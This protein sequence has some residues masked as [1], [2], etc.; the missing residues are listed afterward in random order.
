MFK[1]TQTLNWWTDWIGLDWMDLSQ[2]ITPPRAPCGAK[3]WKRKREKH[4]FAKVKI[5]PKKLVLINATILA[6][7]IFFTN[8]PYSKN[9]VSKSEIFSS[10]HFPTFTK[11]F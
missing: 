3:N 9:V 4:L 8:T 10:S 1:N 5:V 2:N 6:L 11:E 7:C